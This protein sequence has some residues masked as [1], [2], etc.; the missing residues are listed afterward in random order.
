M[1]W[2]RLSAS[3][4]HR[5][6]PLSSLHALWKLDEFRAGASAAAG[7][8]RSATPGRISTALPPGGRPPA[9]AAAAGALRK[10][11]LLILPVVSIYHAAAK[12]P[13][14]F[15]HLAQ[16]VGRRRE[17]QG[18]FGLGVGHESS[19][20]RLR[21]LLVPGQDDGFPQHFA[22]DGDPAAF[23]VSCRFLPGLLRGAV[24]P[25]RSTRPVSG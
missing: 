7:A 4:N 18:H 25:C 8:P 6:H 15:M 14:R 20:R 10:S 12:V 9:K 2:L 21:G 5:A 16:L 1:C 19:R 23:G 22:V 3:Y 24:S 17:K 11:C 13:L